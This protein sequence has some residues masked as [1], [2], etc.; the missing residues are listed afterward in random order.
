MSGVYSILCV[1]CVV[2]WPILI[3]LA[4]TLPDKIIRKGATMILNM[5]QQKAVENGEAVALNVAGTECVLVRRDI[6]VR[7]DPVRE[8]WTRTVAPKQSANG[9]PDK[10]G[11]HEPSADFDPEPPPWMDVEND[12]YFPMTVPSYSLGKVKL[13]VEKGKPCIILP[14]E[15]PDE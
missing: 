13:I 1:Y 10:A 12:V 6:Y 9:T 8:T 7:L 14:E 4:I 5:E 3:F 15:L 2:F 11:P